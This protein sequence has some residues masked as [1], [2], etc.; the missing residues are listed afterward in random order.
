MIW[1]RSTNYDFHTVDINSGEERKISGV[2]EGGERIVYVDKNSIVALS[3]NREMNKMQLIG[4]SHEAAGEKKLFKEMPYSTTTKG[5]KN[6]CR[7][8]SFRFSHETNE[9]YFIILKGEKQDSLKNGSIYK[10]SLNEPDN[11]PEKVKLPDEI[12]SSTSF[13]LNEDGTKIAIGSYAGGMYICDL[14]NCEL[15]KKYPGP[16]HVAPLSFFGNSVIFRG[17]PRGYRVIENDDL[18]KTAVFKPYIVTINE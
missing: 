4:I 11:S 9:L 16:A 18:R 6:S 17:S 12:K 10:V 14:V 5:T 13:E 3:H 1:E 15:I 7:P 8:D 2:I